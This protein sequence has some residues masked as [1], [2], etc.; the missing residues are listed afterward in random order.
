MSKINIV[1][2]KNLEQKFNN[3]GTKEKEFIG[4]NIIIEANQWFMNTEKFFNSVKDSLKD[5]FNS[6]E[7][8]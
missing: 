8:S 2:R 7:K 5:Y 6:I 4:D 1:C 3:S